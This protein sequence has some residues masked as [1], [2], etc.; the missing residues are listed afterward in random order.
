MAT[1][2]KD[3]QETKETR[4]PTDPQPLTLLSAK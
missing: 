2:A 3:P 4:Q 1:I